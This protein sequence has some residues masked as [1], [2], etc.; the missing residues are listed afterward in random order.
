M[1]KQSKY[2]T[3]S[4]F[5]ETI[6]EG[7]GP[8]G[9]VF[10]MIQGLREVEETN[11]RIKFYQFYRTDKKNRNSFSKIMYRV[12]DHYW[13]KI[14]EKRMHKACKYSDL[15]IFQGYQTNKYVKLAKQNKR[16]CVYM[17]HSPYIAADEIK[18]VYELDKKTFP[19]EKYEEIYD[20]EKD[21]FSLSDILIFATRNAAN[22]YYR[23]WNSIIETK[24]VYFIKSGVIVRKATG[25][26]NLLSDYNDKVKICFIGRYIEHKGYRLFC[27]ASQRF[28]GNKDCIFISAGSGPLKGIPESNT[29]KDL[30]FVKGIGNLIKQVD[31]IIIAN[32]V[33]YYD[34]LPLECASYGK[35][36]VMSYVDGNIDQL[37]DLPDTIAFESNNIDSLI[38]KIK[39]AI[40]ISK[41]QKS[42]GKRNQE[43][44][45]NMFTEVA[46]V[47]RWL[48]VIKQ[49]LS[50]EQNSH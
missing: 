47:N 8:M 20:T 46:M 11:T 38:E 31:V 37:E 18:K 42:W 9:Y 34:L 17:P 3:I 10:N 15:C 22:A 24:K 33:A 2:K 50:E 35:P 44:Y 12:F 29:V 1:L 4:I 49:I 40:K 39:D 36:M 27:E 26:I 30:G 25:S 14:N 6:I 48:D 16:L 43:V 21:L 13:R 41:E 23:E 5:T 28:K 45:E 32:T 19:S 7:G